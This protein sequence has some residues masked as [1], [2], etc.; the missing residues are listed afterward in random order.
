V[1]CNS[2]K[3][4]IYKVDSA[5]ELHFNCQKQHSIFYKTPSLHLA[6]FYKYVK[7]DK[8]GYALEIQDYPISNFPFH[9][10]GTK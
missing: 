8:N 10:E 4:F 1:L 7:L 6:M 3:Y 9:L 5:I 2:K